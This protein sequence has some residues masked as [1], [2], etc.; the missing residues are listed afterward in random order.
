MTPAVANR[1]LYMPGRYMPGRYMPGLDAAAALSLR[2]APTPMRNNCDNRPVLSGIPALLV[3]QPKEI[4]DEEDQCNRDRH[5]QPVDPGRRR[6]I[7]RPKLC[8]RQ[9]RNGKVL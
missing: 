3:F 9:G 8:R 1:D 2:R 4:V 6:P 7:G 5:Q